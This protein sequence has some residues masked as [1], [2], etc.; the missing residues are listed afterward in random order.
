MT[1]LLN[2]DKGIEVNAEIKTAQ[3]FLSE[4][5]WTAGEN[6]AEDS[7]TG[8]IIKVENAIGETL[9]IPYEEGD[10]KIVFC[11]QFNE[12]MHWNGH[13]VINV[14]S[15]DVLINITEANYDDGLLL[16]YKQAFVDN[17]SWYTSNRKIIDCI[18]GYDV[19]DGET[20]RY[21]YSGDIRM[22]FN[23]LEVE[24]KDIFTV[25]RLRIGE[26]LLEYYQGRTYKGKYSDGTGNAI[27]N[28]LF[29]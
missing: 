9:V 15:Q 2:D 28:M 10:K 3:G 23:F 27:F 29:A 12:N 14:Y 25:D 4:P 20:W 22:S 21:K 17:G 18:N 1:L 16:S 8:E 26:K 5:M 11:G 13:C 19:S 24:S 7:T 6:F